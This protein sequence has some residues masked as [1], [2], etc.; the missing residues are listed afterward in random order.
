MPS[1][2]AAHCEHVDTI[3]QALT[4][5]TPNESGRVATH[6]ESW[7]ATSTESIPEGASVRVTR[8]DGLL[9]TVRKD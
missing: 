8:V 3:G 4:A 2:I 9:L 5:I 6:G 7:Q 1:R